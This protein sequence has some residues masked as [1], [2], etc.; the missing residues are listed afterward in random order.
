MTHDGAP[1]CE[2]HDERVPMQL[3]TLHSESSRPDT[4]VGLYECPECGF[5]RRQ[6]I[7]NLSAETSAA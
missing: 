7:E 4:V 1:H 5:E 2:R 6:P 3:R